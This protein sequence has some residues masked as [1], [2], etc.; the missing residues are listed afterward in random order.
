MASLFSIMI[1]R[2]CGSAKLPTLCSSSKQKVQNDFEM[3]K[4]LQL[5]DHD[6]VSTI[7]TTT[8]VQLIYL[9]KGIHLKQ[10]L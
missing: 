4:K 8:T 5:Q 3:E 6:R 10:H 9:P 7:C 1:F 2:I